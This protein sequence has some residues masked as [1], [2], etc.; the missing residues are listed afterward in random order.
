MTVRAFIG[1]PLPVTTRQLLS[2]S[3]SAMRVSSP[4]WRT[5]KWVAEENLHITLKFMGDL[6]AGLL[7]EVGRVM[8]ATAAGTPAFAIT[9]GDVVPIPRMRAATMLWSTLAEGGERVVRLAND[10][11]AALAAAGFTAE[12]RPFKPHITLVRARRPR[13]AGLDL[14]DAGQL[15]IIRG[16]ERARRVSV[17]EVTLFTSTLTAQGPVYR[18]H[19]TVTLAG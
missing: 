15:S 14:L 7:D 8:A 6:P 18:D 9:V 13:R 19:L 3:C 16:D 11:D 12:T 17:R 2:A 5:E 4:A 1:V 10:M